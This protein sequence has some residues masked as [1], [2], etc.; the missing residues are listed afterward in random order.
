MLLGKLCQRSSD[1]QG[2]HR[3]LYGLDWVR[4]I[5]RL[6]ID[7]ILVAG[8]R[9][10]HVDRYAP[11]DREQ[12]R[13]DRLH[14]RVHYL[15]MAPGSHQGFLDD[16]LGA[17]AIAERELKREPHQRRALTIPQLLDGF[18]VGETPASRVDAVGCLLQ[19]RDQRK[20]RSLRLSQMMS[21][22]VHESSLR[23]RARGAL[24]VVAAILLVQ[25]AGAHRRTQ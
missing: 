20:S 6:V 16:V 22:S 1:V 9:S 2:R 23:G 8:P 12:P 17:L 3:L 24:L 13:P 5:Q 25:P 14:A 15:G 19:P 21:G 10:P 18:I 11:R 7:D 4:A